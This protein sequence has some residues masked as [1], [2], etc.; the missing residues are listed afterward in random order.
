MKRL[1]FIILVM[2]LAC[3]Q[4]VAIDDVSHPPKTTV[5]DKKYEN[6]FKPLDGTWRGQFII[7]TDTRGQ[8]DSPVQP[9]DIT[10]KTLR[11]LPLQEQ[12]VIDVKQIYESVTPY[13]QKVTIFD[14]Y[15]NVKGE[16]Q[17]VQSHGV[18]KIQD[19][20]LWCVV[21]KPDETVIHSGH[22]EGGQTIV[23][24]RHLTK[25]LKIEYF[26]ETVSGDFYSILGWGYYGDDH[27]DLSPGYWFKGLYKKVGK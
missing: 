24:Q 18:N 3:Q 8:G 27:P 21:L 5:N 2:N 9:K 4:Q 15:V 26:K 12:S 19:G 13:F 22:L 16:R 6:I 14:T 11:N 17:V 25:P 10:E 7:F 1:A 20:K 23:W